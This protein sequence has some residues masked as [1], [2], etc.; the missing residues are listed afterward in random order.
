[1]VSDTVFASKTCTQLDG[2]ILPEN[3]IYANKYYR[4]DLSPRKTDFRS[5]LRS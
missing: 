4:C 5:V 3:K 2:R 1:M